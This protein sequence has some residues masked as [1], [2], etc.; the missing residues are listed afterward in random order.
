MTPE[1]AGADFSPCL[2][3]LRA[4]LPC[5][6][7][8]G[9]DMAVVVIMGSDS[10]LEQVSPCLEILDK[11]AV[12]YQ[13]R[14]FSAHRTPAQLHN[15]INKVEAKTGIYICA[16]GGAAH[17]A[18]VVA[19]LT[20]KPVIGIPMLGQSLAGA[21]SL[22]SMVQMPAGVPVA[23]MGIGKSGAGNAGLLAVQILAL[24]DAR[25][26]RK[27]VR[28]RIKMARTVIAKDKSLQNKIKKG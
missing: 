27:I 23:V 4:T 3:L 26:R 1:H 22:Y 21:D 12:A 10:D 9:S 8:A 15:F 16:A 6:L 19:S 14:V 18:G 24:S 28:H 25:L 13:A 7:F 20:V 11:F 5:R 17:L 2:D